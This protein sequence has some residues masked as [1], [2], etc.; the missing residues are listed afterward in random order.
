MRV[1]SCVYYCNDDYNIR[2]SRNYICI[3]IKN[4]NESLNPYYKYTL[5]V[6]M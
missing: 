1:T 4:K 2:G 5:T 6:R 3:V